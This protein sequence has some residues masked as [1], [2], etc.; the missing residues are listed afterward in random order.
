MIKVIKKEA[1]AVLGG[2]GADCG[3]GGN[4]S[5]SGTR[6]PCAEEIETELNRWGTL[7]KPQTL[8]TTE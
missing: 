6:T 8:T 5:Y 2:F 1:Q 7:R 3:V 4:D